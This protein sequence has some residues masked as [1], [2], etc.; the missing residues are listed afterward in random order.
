MS[1]GSGKAAKVTAIVFATIII[2]F[3]VGSFFFDRAVLGK[4]YER[5][6]QGEPNLLPSYEMYAGDYPRTPVEFQLDGSTLRGYVYHADNPRAFI[7]FRHGIFS[8]HNDYLALITAMVDRG[9]TVYAY[10]A[11]GCGE[12]DGDSTIGMAQSAID[13]AAALQ[14]VRSNNLN[15]GLPIVLWG[16]SWGGYGVAAA[17]DIDPDVAACITMSGYN[18]PCGILFE[19]TEK[20]MG[21]LGVTQ[22]ATIWLNNKLTFGNDSD[23]TAVSG[24]NK[25]E[26]PVLVIHG[27]DDAVISFE[28]ASII[29]QSASITNPMAEYCTIDVEGRNGH[30]SYFYS[31]ESAQ[32][33]AD[34]N[35]E[36]A[37]L[38]SQYPDGVPDDV[39]DTFMGNFDM[40]RANEASPELIS[41][42]DDFLTQVV[43]RGGTKDMTTSNENE[44]RFGELR[45][46]TFSNSGNSLGNLYNVTAERA[47]DGSMVVTVRQAE[48]HSDPTSVSEYRAPDDLLDQVAAIADKAG[49]KEW[50]ELP[51]SEFV[52]M[53]A[54]TPTVRLEYASADADSLLPIWL[55]YSTFDELPDNGDSLWAIRDLLESYATQENIIRT[56][57]EA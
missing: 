40:R 21:L 55:T 42:I 29:A 46:A 57:T 49:M 17:M 54:S 19:T 41:I 53:D 23:R 11:I 24:I 25:T 51:L 26:A 1:A 18:D 45:S 3:F 13:V 6:Q 37:E 20:Q 30:N 31:V 36:L 14:F 5:V 16:H 10:D 33:L 22:E 15:D 39:L 4:T 34:K 35:A 48:T 7:V 52:V 8:Q 43:G 47:D 56:Y 28:G 12:S 27:T 50:G 9:Y 32:Y 38:K 44:N 2:V